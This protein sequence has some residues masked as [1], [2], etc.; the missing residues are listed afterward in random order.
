MNCKTDKTNSVSDCAGGTHTF[1][2]ANPKPFRD[3]K[4]QEY[5]LDLI[6]TRD[7]SQENNSSIHR[8]SFYKAENGVPLK[9]RIHIDSYAFQS[10]AKVEMLT[11]DG[12]KSLNS[13]PYPE[14]S[15]TKRKVN[16]YSDKSKITPSLDEDE[17]NLLATARELIKHFQ[18][19][20]ED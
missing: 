18:N 11:P 10:S 6:Q 16:F 5:T 14:M 19:Q 1:K 7:W 3:L 17:A 8:E 4:G 9:V 15:A 2:P 12:W 13:I 20:P